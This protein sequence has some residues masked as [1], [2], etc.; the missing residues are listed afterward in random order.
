[1]SILSKVTR[2]AMWKNR[3]RT[4]VTIIGIILSAAMFTAVTT[5]GYSLW[6]YMRE[7][8]IYETGDYYLRIDYATQSHVDALAEDERVS[9]IRTLGMLGYTEF[10]LQNQ[11]GYTARQLCGVA[12]GDKDFYDTVTIALEE[13][14]LPQ[15]SDEIVITRNI[16]HYLQKAGRPCELGDSVT[17]DIVPRYEAYDGDVPLPEDGEAFSKTYTIVG[18]GETFSRLDDYKLSLC[19]LFTYA[20]A[21]NGAIWYRIYLKTHDPKDAYAL[22]HEM[23][24]DVSGSVN[25]GLLQLYGAT[26]YTNFDTMILWVCAVLIA[27]IMVGSVSLIYNAFSISVSERTKEFG[28]L[29]SVGATRKQ[30]RGAVYSEAVLLSAI[31]IPLGLLSGYAGIAVTL[32]LLSTRIHTMLSTGDGTIL[33][34]PVLS[35]AAL[36][37]AAVIALITVL[38]SAAI[39]ARR[40]AKISPIDAIRQKNDYLVPKKSIRV[41]K[42]T[43]K[44]FGL[45]A[46]LAR[47]YY[48]VSRKKYRATV[49][50]LVISIVLFVSAASVSQLI[51]FTVDRAVNTENYDMMCFGDRET[52]DEIRQQPFVKDSVLFSTGYYMIHVTDEQLDESYLD[53]W[54]SIHAE[55]D[56]F[57]KNI[58]DVTLIYLE[59]EVFRQY[60]KENGLPE[61]P[62][63]TD[64]VPSALVVAKE[65]VVYNF[66]G[67]TG[68]TQ[69]YTYAYEPYDAEGAVIPLMENVLPSWLD[70]MELDGKESARSFERF[71]DEEGNTVLAIVP[72]IETEDDR[73]VEDWENREEYLIRWDSGDDGIT[74]AGY[75]KRDVATGVVEETA[76]F[77]ETLNTPLVKLG[78][79]VTELPF[80][81]S[82]D[83]ID[84]YYYNYMILPMSRAPENAFS[85]PDLCIT[86]SDYVAAKTYLQTHLGEQNLRDLKESEENNRTM[87]LLIDVFSYGFIVLISLICVANVFNTISTNVAL[88]RRDFGMLRSTGFREKDLWKMMQ[89]ECLSYGGKAM[90]WG[91]PIS[92]AASYLI[93]HMDNSISSK[94][95]TLPWD[96]LVIAALCVFLVVF[97]TMS[98][99]VS[100]LRKDNTID[101]IRMET[102]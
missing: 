90:L 72:I 25:A 33:L 29:G 56:F 55:Y 40:A 3:T 34:K 30:I 59:D 85:G 75:Y 84:G 83:A 80:G 5:L 42:L 18:I 4:I 88:R 10:S 26:P 79:T 48:K 27:I 43:G 82:Y 24:E 21:D 89:Y 41:S 81:V 65:V 64:A 68:E 37:A 16:Y 62:Y 98:Y 78:A 101:A 12:A 22:Y 87:I 15:S 2:K 45:P 39:P 61:E 51:R 67:Q 20:D 31:G 94:G 95:F 14:R 70:N 77:T 96:A 69:R 57:D 100:K 49:I 97:V 54:E 52:L 35:L 6:S 38:I 86:V 66:S 47:K 32:N 74:A 58:H 60:L 93:Q 36:G 46:V 91:I 8:E 1:M 50:S 63:F 7:T 102:V 13:G 99:A 23:P 11:D 71:T 17:L 73:L 92:L 28:I 19:H 44:L 76:A 9:R 53:C